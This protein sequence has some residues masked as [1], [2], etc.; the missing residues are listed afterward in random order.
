[1]GNQYMALVQLGNAPGVVAD[2]IAHTGRAKMLVYL[3]S[4]HA[5]V[6][7]VWMTK[8]SKF[9]TFYGP[10][11]VEQAYTGIVAVLVPI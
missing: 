1:M 7:L 6:L 11:L 4:T 5:M 10:G 3:E 2:A 9:G 8:G